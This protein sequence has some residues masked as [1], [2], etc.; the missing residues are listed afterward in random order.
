M[1]GNN[2][3]MTSLLALLD[4]EKFMKDVTSSGID[5]V[6]VKYY[7]SLVEKILHPKGNQGQSKSFN[8]PSEGKPAP[9]SSIINKLCCQIT[10]EAL[11][12]NDA[13]RA[14]EL[15]FDKLSSFSWDAK[16]VL[17][18]SALSVY[19]AENRHHAETEK[20]YKLVL[21]AELRGSRADKSAF[22][23]LEDLI[24][25]ILE[26]TVCTV[27]FANYSESFRES[28]SID[29]R[30]RFYQIIVGVVGCSV[31]FCGMIS[32]SNEFLE[33]NLLPFSNRVMKIYK[34]FKKEVEN[35]KQENAERLRYKQI[36]GL[37][38][39]TYDILGRMAVLFCTEKDSPTVYHCSEKT[40]VKLE[41]FQKKNV[42]LLISGLDLSN[43]DFILLTSIYS[44][45]TFKSSNYEIMWVPI[46][47][48]EDAV[49]EEQFQKKG[50]Q[51]PW[52]SCNSIVS[53]AS[54]KFIKKYWHYKQQ[55]KVVVLNQEGKV[56]NMDAMTMIRLSGS[57]A[58]PFTLERGCKLWDA[59]R[60]N[61]LK[62][63]VNNTVFQSVEQSFVNR[64]L[65]FLCGSAEDSKTVEEIEN[66]LSKIK[67][68]VKFFNINT[69]RK[70]FLFRLENCISWMM[71]ANKEMPN[72]LMPGLPELY[73][74]YKKQ[75]GFAIVARGSSVI[76]NTSVTDLLKVLSKHE[77]INNVTNTQDFET[78]FV[79]CHNK[80]APPSQ[81]LEFSIPNMVGD[82]PEYTKCP[83][84]DC[85]LN[86]E[87]VTTFKCCHG[88]H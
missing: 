74:S 12:T 18:L 82:M 73:S 54:A 28:T 88:K 44:D 62:L 6:D 43:D 31:P 67:F 25:V 35:F 69:K 22:A 7:L 86:M 21:A 58:L 51:M 70:Q 30:A 77:L 5:Q 29:I 15:L 78:H 68:P 41:V 64:E 72:S 20:D 55:T 53:K 80:V 57:E 52:Y 50:S 71:Q 16:A 66:H 37:Y 14:M 38:R 61:W 26:F 56:V 85:T 76:V 40:T 9:L 10:C 46:A 4:S 81:C 8:P 83:K 60:N 19:Y 63:L 39:S 87:T 27:E 59:H 47:D 32:T 36:K 34:S 13:S 23:V 42:M 11:H 3:F 1:A 24:R 49:M 17:T 2:S 65:I 75:S 45:S 79:A 33:L 48:V 84:A